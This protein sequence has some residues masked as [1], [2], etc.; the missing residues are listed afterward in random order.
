MNPYH[1]F[2]SI[3]NILCGIAAIVGWKYEIRGL[4]PLAVYVG[5]FANLIAVVVSLVLIVLLITRV[6][7]GKAKELLSTSWLGFLNGFVVV[8]AWGVFIRLSMSE[9]MVAN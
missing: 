2:I 4:L 7:S 1:I 8:V 3:I 9:G 6:P 5:Y